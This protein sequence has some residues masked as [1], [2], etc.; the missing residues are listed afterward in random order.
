MDLKKA[1]TQRKSVKQYHPKKKPSWKKVLRAIDLARFAPT[2]GGIFNTKFIL[3]RDKK[4]IEQLGTATYQE[5]TKEAN[6]MIIIISDLQKM[7]K[8]YGDRGLKYSHQ[9]AGATIQNILLGLTEQNIDHCWIGYFED[10]K[11]IDILNIP[12]DKNIEAIITIG[13]Q[14]KKTKET[15]KEKVELEDTIN[16]E[17]WG[18][19]T[20]PK[21]RLVKMDIA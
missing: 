16:Y 21:E 14:S 5:F 15:K 8:H 20:M 10:K 19:N 6:M 12:K 9:Q 18:K 2:A 1:I 3:V 4:T 17:E 7:I 11:I 13:K